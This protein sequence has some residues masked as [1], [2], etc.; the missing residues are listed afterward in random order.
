[1]DRESPQPSKAP[2]KSALERVMDLFARREHSEQEL[3]AKLADRYP[4]HEIHAAIAHARAQKWLGDERALAERYAEDLHQKGKG[5]LY[6]NEKLA[7]KGLPPV[8]E[9]PERELEK[10]R[11]LAKTKWARAE[12]PEE[13]D[14][15]KIGRFLQSR[16]FD[17]ELVRKVIYEKF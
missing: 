15:E 16:G 11:K 12:Q 5:L 17:P 10:A 1:M 9:D 4:E 14:R 7:A 2:T 6:I 3:R 13:E 8:A